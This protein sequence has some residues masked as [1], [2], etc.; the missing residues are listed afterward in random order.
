MA[1]P[2]EKLATALEEL[3][4]LQRD[5]SSIFKSDQF[6]RSVRERLLK[7][8]FLREVMRGWVMSSSPTA[9]QG[10]T[11]P[12]YASFW[13]FCRRYCEE[14]FGTDWHLSPEQSLL[15]HAENTTIPKQVIIHGPRATDDRIDL[16]FGTSFFA[17]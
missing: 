10:D 13:E 6:S 1:T 17:L 16:L 11:T 4:R 8:G 14:R 15:L 12:W 7:H 9:T 5:G 3:S 2:N